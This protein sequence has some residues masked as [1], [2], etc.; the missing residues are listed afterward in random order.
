[1]DSDLEALTNIIITILKNDARRKKN[2]EADF[3]LYIK[4]IKYLEL[5]FK[6]SSKVK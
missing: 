5:S 3:G 2:K 1:M 6:F 4:I